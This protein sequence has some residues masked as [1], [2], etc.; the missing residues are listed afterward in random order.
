MPRFANVV[1]Q[2]K[3]RGEKKTKQ[4]AHMRLSLQMSWLSP[5]R[6]KLWLLLLSVIRDVTTVSYSMA[7]IGKAQRPRREKNDAEKPVIARTAHD[8]QRL[9]L[10]KLMKN[11]VCNSDVLFVL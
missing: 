9:K 10:E 4:L 11:A 3:G 2:E 6:V 5:V 8:L 1:K 7:Q